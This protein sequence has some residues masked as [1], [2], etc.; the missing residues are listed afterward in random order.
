MKKVICTVLI[1]VTWC[2]LF[3]TASVQANEKINNQ[4]PLF[5]LPK[6]MCLIYHG[7]STRR[8][9]KADDFIPYLIYHDKETANSTPLFDAFLLIEYRTSDGKYFW[10]EKNEKQIA[11]VKDWAWLAQVWHTCL[12]ELNEAVKNLHNKNVIKEDIGIIITIPEPSL[13]FKNFGSLSAE[14]SN[15]NFQ[16]ETD[17]ITAI[18][19]YIEKVIT[20]FSSAH[21]SNLKLLGFYWL[22]ESIPPEMENTVK[23]TADII[24][25]ANLLFFW[26]PYFTA[27]NVWAWKKLGFDFMFYQPNYFFEGKGGDIRLG[28]TAYRVEQFNCGVE[29]EL[30]DRILNSDV[31][32]LRFLK[33]VQ[34]GAQFKWNQRPMAWYQANDTIYKLVKS[35]NEKQQEIYQTI[36]RFITQTYQP[37]R[38]EPSIL[39]YKIP[40]HNGFNLAHR[41]NGTKV[42]EPSS[43]FC[44]SLNPEWAIDGD[45]DCYSGTSGFACCEIPGKIQIQF[46][47]TVT[48]TCVQ[49]LLFN[50]DERYYQYRIETS[51]DGNNWK[52]IIDKSQG[53]YRG[54]QKDT[55][56]PHPARYLQVIPLLNSTGQNL[57]QIVELEVY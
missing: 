53:E 28:L 15:L 3:S 50:L 36:A 16:N 37:P 43:G 33:Y 46:A 19:W 27:N 13:N 39:E 24:H 52:T 11:D 25:Q 14:A 20:E 35:E 10:G 44:L 21:Y 55:V 31:H 45:V 9:W 17:R 26:I 51:Q 34:A 38:T 5:T 30:D 40:D 29:I 23:Q 4:S 54:W 57:F 1:F 12:N 56:S 18:R 48:I 6:N 8:Q 42:I 2:S 41:N 47:D 49:M 32:Q 22:G 7:S